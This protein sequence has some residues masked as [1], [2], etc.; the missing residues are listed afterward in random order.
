MAGSNL[1]SCLE[2]RDLLNRQDVHGS[3]LLSWGRRFEDAGLVHDAVSFYEKGDAVEELRRLLRDAQEEGD[4]FL[5]SRISRAIRCEP[6]R[7]QWLLIA[8]RAG[9]LGKQ[10]FAAEARR[11]AGEHAEEET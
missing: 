8:G 2:K 6:D 3:V 4:V 11:R 5:F 1:L 9:E 7:E 10:A